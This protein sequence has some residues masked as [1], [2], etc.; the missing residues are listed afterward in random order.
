MSSIKRTARQA[1]LL[2]LV[3][4]VPAVFSLQYFPRAFIVSGNAA[5]TAQRITDGALTYRFLVLSELVTYVGFLFLVWALYHLFEEVDKRVAMLMVI[6][7]SVSAAIGMVNIINTMAPLVLLSGA[8]FLSVFTKPQLDA[9]ALSFLRLRN[10]GI[11]VNMAFWGLWL[12]PFGVLVIKSGFVPKILGIFLI[13]GCFAYLAV[14]LTAMVL[15]AH[16]RVANQ[17]ALPFFALAE[18]PIWIWLLKGP[19]VEPS[20]A[21][22]AGAGR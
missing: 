5:A 18:L 4:G 11:N 16:V 17:I 19:S 15:P 3:M 6:L 9:L 2:Y 10:G 20:E 12:F 22:R 14:C 21:Q 8:D 7:V 13:V 1:G